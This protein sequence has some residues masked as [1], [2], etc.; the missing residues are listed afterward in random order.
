M[1]NNDYLKTTNVLGTFYFKKIAEQQYLCVGQ[2]SVI[3]IQN[4][5][6]IYIF[7]GTPF[8]SVDSTEEEFMKVYNET[9]KQITTMINHKNNEQVFTTVDATVIHGSDNTNSSSG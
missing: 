8:V 3:P 7:L 6:S 5:P 2:T 4:K 1:N 9:V